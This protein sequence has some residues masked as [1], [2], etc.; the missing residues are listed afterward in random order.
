[1]ER[2]ILSESRVSKAHSKSLSKARSHASRDHSLFWWSLKIGCAATLISALFLKVIYQLTP[3]FSAPVILA[4][5]LVFVGAAST[6][7]HYRQLKRSS[8]NIEQPAALVQR[9]GL[10]KLIRHP[11]YLS[12]MLVSSGLFLLFPTVPTIVVLAVGLFALVR[13]SQVEDQYMQQRF[14]AEFQEWQGKTKLIL[15]FIY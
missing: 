15:P 12:D 4:Q 8:N 2:S 5:A 14:D 6:L 3:W 11:M 10:F 1:M 9:P 13:Q 7:W